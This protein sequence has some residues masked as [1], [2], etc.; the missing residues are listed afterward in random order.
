MPC[1][2]ICLSGRR[3]V[4]CA[5]YRLYRQRADNGSGLRFLRKLAGSGTMWGSGE[6]VP[7]LTL[8]LYATTDS[9]IGVAF[10]VLITSPIA[11]IASDL[12]M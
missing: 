1:L 8:R 11:A 4:L 2:R 3:R 9:L 5:A 6:A 7:L 10:V 12:L